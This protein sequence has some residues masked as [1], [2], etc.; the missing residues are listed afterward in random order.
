MAS[1][2]QNI[3]SDAEDG[4][5][6]ASGDETVGKDDAQD[7]SAANALPAGQIEE[8]DASPQRKV[9]FP[10]NCISV[11]FESTHC[12]SNYSITSQPCL[13]FASHMAS[14][15]PHTRCI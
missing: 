14:L 13:S 7:F 2:P 11:Y 6:S 12:I 4:E 5:I 9:F 1:P 3:G 8:E 10:T 15:F